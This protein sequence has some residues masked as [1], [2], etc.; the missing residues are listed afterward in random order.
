M[1]FAGLYFGTGIC[2]VFSSSILDL[3]IVAAGED[4]SS[5]YWSRVDDLVG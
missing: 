5:T 2:I 4:K 1:K 3:K